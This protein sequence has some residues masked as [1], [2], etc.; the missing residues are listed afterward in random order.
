MNAAY[1]DHILSI[2]GVSAPVTFRAVLD[3]IE[4]IFSPRARQILKVFGPDRKEWG[5]YLDREISRDQLRPEFGGT[6]AD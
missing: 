6:K 3:V 5:Q 1:A 4:P 2:T